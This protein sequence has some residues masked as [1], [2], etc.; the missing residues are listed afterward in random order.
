MM[1]TKAYSQDVFVRD[2]PRDLLL[3]L[4]LVQLEPEDGYEKGPQHLGT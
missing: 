2:V 4:L 3:A 1:L